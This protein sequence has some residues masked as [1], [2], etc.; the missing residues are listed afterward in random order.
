MQTN[1]QTVIVACS[2]TNH[3]CRSHMVFAARQAPIAPP[4]QRNAEITKAPISRPPRRT[5]AAD[6]TVSEKTTNSMTLAIQKVSA[7]SLF[8]GPTLWTDPAWIAYR[9]ARMYTAVPAV[10]LAG[11]GPPCASP[12]TSDCITYLVSH[13]HAHARHR[14]SPRSLDPSPA[15]RL[16][17][18]RESVA[19]SVTPTRDRHCS[20]SSGAPARLS[21]DPPVP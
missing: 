10:R 14:L 9:T 20:V 21:L 8:A 6:P 19:P 1:A 2:M 4:P 13:E 5:H 3:G 11:D 18:S 17:A 7:A 16:P 12:R 15:A